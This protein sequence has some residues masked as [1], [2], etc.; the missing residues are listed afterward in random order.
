MN[1]ELFIKFV[2]LS[3]VELLCYIVYLATLLVTLEYNC[4]T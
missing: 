4:D 1:L 3:I 2:L